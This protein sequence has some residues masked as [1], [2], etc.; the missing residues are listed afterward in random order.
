MRMKTNKKGFA[1]DL[2]LATGISKVAHLIADMY[3]T[4]DKGLA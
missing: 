1:L 4:G 3:P 2:V